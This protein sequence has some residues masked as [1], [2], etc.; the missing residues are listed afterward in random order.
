MHR[1]VQLDEPVAIGKHM[2]QGLWN[3]A[4]Q[5]G[6]SNMEWGG[7]PGV[8][9]VVALFFK[10]PKLNS[11]LTDLFRFEVGRVGSSNKQTIKQTNGCSHLRPKD[12]DL[13][14]FVPQFGLQV[15]PNFNQLGCFCS[16]ID[17]RSARTGCR[18]SWWIW[19]TSLD[20]DLLPIICPES[21]SKEM[22]NPLN[23]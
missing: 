9:R 7:E 19:R 13:S 3:T 10:P 15:Q 12:I 22:K 21:E 4:K 23:K 16:P 5:I 17:I 1:D 18:S 11:L 14:L 8:A 2:Y 6:L 20:L